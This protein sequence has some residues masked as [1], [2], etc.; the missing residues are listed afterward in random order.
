[1]FRAIH[2]LGGKNAG[3]ISI[4]EY[5]CLYDNQRSGMLALKVVSIEAVVTLLQYVVPI[6]KRMA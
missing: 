2:Y 5:R 1:M 3:Y 4:Y 6:Q